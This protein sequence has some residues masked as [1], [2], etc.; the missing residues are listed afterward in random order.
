MGRKESNKT[1][2]TIAMTLELVVN[3]SEFVQSTLVV[4][5]GV[6]CDKMHKK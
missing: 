1:N 3:F 4:M 6:L 5:D 2:K